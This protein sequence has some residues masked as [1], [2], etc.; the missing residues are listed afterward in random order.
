MNQSE[1]AHKF[2]LEIQNDQWFITNLKK[3]SNPIRDEIALSLEEN[4]ALNNVVRSY[5]KWI[6]EMT[7]KGY[8]V[9]IPSPGAFLLINSD[10]K[11]AVTFRY[12]T[13]ITEATKRI[14]KVYNE[15]IEIIELHSIEKGQG[16][17]IM[18]EFIALSHKIQLPLAL[19]TETEELVRYYQKYDFHNHG[20]LGSNNEFLMLRIPDS[21]VR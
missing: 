10:I 2:F 1:M 18:N 5:L 12:C 17:K 3:H 21:I 6:I 20:K 16:S 14:L 9:S 15:C 4:F 8:Y 19:Y 13:T 11:S 7:E